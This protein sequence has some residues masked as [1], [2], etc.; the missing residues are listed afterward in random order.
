MQGLRRFIIIALLSL[1]SLTLIG[2]S[3]ANVTGAKTGHPVD[4]TAVNKAVTEIRAY[5]REV[6]AAKWRSRVEKLEAH[7]AE[8]Q[9]QYDEHM[10]TH[11]SGPAGPS[12]PSTP[13]PPGAGTMAYGSGGYPGSHRAEYPGL[14][15]SMPSGASFVYGQQVVRYDADLGMIPEDQPVVLQTKGTTR[16]E[17]DA[18]LASFPATREAPIYLLYQNEPDNPGKISP[19]VWGT[20]TDMLY[21]AIDASGKDYVVKSLS[22]MHYTLVRDLAGDA[23]RQ[24]D[25]WIRP[26]LEHIIWSAFSTNKLGDSDGDGEP[27]E[28]TGKNARPQ[29]V[30]QRLKAFSDRLG[31][32]WS[33]VGGWGIRSSE[34]RDPDTHA[35]RVAYLREM[36]PTLESHGALMYLWFNKSWPGGEGNFLI[37]ADP[38]LHNAWKALAS[39]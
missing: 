23:S 35:N 10:A 11:P 12:G 39:S 18:M 26:G 5:E 27:E 38:A 34:W 29:V 3:S 14:V 28:I 30:A 17:Y 25:P 6:E 2:V 13:P 32:S 8:L 4:N 19:S 7:L 15:T 37:A 24:M 21:D 36:G 1:V 31:V 20:R 22:I 16:A 9:R 33:V